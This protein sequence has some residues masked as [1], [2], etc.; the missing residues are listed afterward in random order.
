MI[1]KL[2]QLLHRK[3]KEGNHSGIQANDY[4]MINNFIY[5]IKISWLYNKSYIIILMVSSVAAALYQ[6]MGIYLPKIALELVSGNV[7]ENG[8]ILTI[9]G[10]GIIMLLL[11]FIKN[12]SEYVM[13]YGVDKIRYRLVGE[14]LDKVFSTDFSNME[15]PDFLD[16]Q[17]RAIRAT[18]R[19]GGFNG[20][21]RRAKYAME[22]ILLAVIASVAI[23][24]IHP[25]LILLLGVLSFLSYK[26]FDLTMKWNKREYSD[27]MEGNWRKH[28]YL[29]GTTRDF[30][31]AKD[32]RLFGMADWIE[33]TWKDINNVFFKACKKRRNKWIWCEV[34]MSL[35][36]LIQNIVL[37]SVLIYM[38]LN[39]GMSIADFVLY[40]G[41]VASFS[42]AMTDLFSN[43]V[44]MGMNKMQMDDYRTFMSW[45]EAAP[46]HSKGE[47]RLKNIHLDKY[48]FTFENVSFKYPGHE[49]YVLRNVNLTIQ[50]GMKLAIVGVNGAGKTTMTKLL[51]RLYEPTEGRILLNGVDVKQYDKKTYYKIFAPVF[52]NIEVLAFPIWENI[53]MKKEADTD[54][55][56][57]E[58]SLKRSGLDAKISKYKK[59]MDT[60][61]LKIFDPEGIDL[62]GGER[63]RLA[64]ARALYQNRDVIVLDEPTAALDALAENRMYQEFNRMVEGKTSI[65]ISHRLSSTRFC[66]RIVMFDEGSVI[67]IGTHEE[68]LK[69]K[70]RY[71]EMYQIQAQYY[72]EANHEIA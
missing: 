71:A 3:K 38:L 5:A 37:Y 51:M 21:C 54:R 45:K 55:N 22:Q 46:D 56:M 24:R 15:N 50:A 23:I 18:Y 52:Q 61:L 63:Q 58:E 68:L 69:Q 42:E 57:V 6:L 40:V 67:E 28:Y 41:M 60:Q 48:E 44:W 11:S 39:K 1:Q 66:D 35:V 4:G 2:K 9:G 34:K 49:K 62:S 26:I 65:F 43:L 27:A 17:Q 64:M 20:Y 29:S 53:S 12:K 8:M 32:I 59:G 30:N 47:G 36:R 70:G 14:Y 7:T 16:L 19:W 13:E 10:V 33:R 31:Y 72:R 25:L